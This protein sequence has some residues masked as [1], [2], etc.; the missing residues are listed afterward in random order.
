MAAKKAALEEIQAAEDSQ[1][2]QEQ[3][4]IEWKVSQLNHFPF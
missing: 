4:T 1:N 3:R 2:D